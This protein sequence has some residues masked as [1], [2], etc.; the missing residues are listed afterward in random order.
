MH[1][2]TRTMYIIYMTYVKGEGE[3]ISYKTKS[4]LKG[5]F[6]GG[7]GNKKKKSLLSRFSRLFSNTK[8]ENNTHVDKISLLRA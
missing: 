3:F 7:L 4:E 6:P 8:M 2:C 1:V 5:Y